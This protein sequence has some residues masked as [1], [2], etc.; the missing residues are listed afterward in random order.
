MSSNFSVKAALAGPLQFTYPLTPTVSIVTTV[1]GDARNN[2]SVQIM[3]GSLPLWAGTMMQTFPQIKTPFD[4]ILGTI[5]I[6]AGC[7]FNLT[8]PTLSQN[9]SVTMQATITSGGVT[10]PFGAI[11]ANWPLTSGA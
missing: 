1:T 5:T 4:L 11:I 2:A 7:T 6:A 3:N 10:T 8:I 9:G